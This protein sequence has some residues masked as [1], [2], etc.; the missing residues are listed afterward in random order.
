MRVV[1]SVVDLRRRAASAYCLDS[2]LLYSLTF[3]PSPEISEFNGLDAFGFRVGVPGN[4]RIEL[5]SG[6]GPKGFDLP[7]DNSL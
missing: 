6:F 3:V 4:P 1:T 2:V 5:P 7:R